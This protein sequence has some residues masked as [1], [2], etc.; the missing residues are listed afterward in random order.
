MKPVIV[1]R[2]VARTLDKLNGDWKGDGA[3]EALA[4]SF[5]ARCKKRDKKAKLER[6]SRK[7]NRRK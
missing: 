7:K 6:A 5:L 2:A 1:N 3:K 4:K